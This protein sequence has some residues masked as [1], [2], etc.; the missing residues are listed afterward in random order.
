MQGIDQAAQLARSPVS[1]AGQMSVEA[2]APCFAEAPRNLM[3]GK[4]RQALLSWQ[5][6]AS[7]AGAARA[8]CQISASAGPC[9]CCCAAR[10]RCGCAPACSRSPR[11]ARA[12][13]ST[14]RAPAGSCP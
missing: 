7:D 2:L 13:R 12:R 9:A 1:C 6:Q 10:R 14:P 11:A 8:R 3:T 4:P 5:L